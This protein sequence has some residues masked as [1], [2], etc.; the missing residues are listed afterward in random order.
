M[1]SAATLGDLL[2]SAA[3]TDGDAA[4]FRYGDERLSYAEWDAL[5]TRVAGGLAAAGVRRGDVVALLLPTTPLYMVCYLGAARLGAVTTGINV[6]YRR[7]EIGHILRRSGTTMLI[8]AE[9]WHDVDFRSIVG[10]LRAGVPELRAARWVPGDTLRASTRDALDA[11]GLVGPAPTHAPDADDPVAIVWTSGTTGVPKGAWYAHRNLLALAE[12]EARRHEGG[13]PRGERHLAS[14]LS[15]AHVGA[16]ARI[17][18]QLTSLGET[19]I[20]DTFEP[21]TVLAAIERER[22]VNLGAFPTQAIMLLDHPECARRDL[23]SLRAVLLG[24]AP[25]SPALIRRVQ[26]TFGVRVAV[27]YSSTEVG[28]ATGSLPDDPIEVLST[29]VGKPTPGVELRIV[30]EERREL[31]AGEIG[32]V[33]VRSPATMRGYWRDPD[34]TAAVLDADGWV[35]TG[36][37]GWLDGDGYLHLRG[38]QS[39]MFIRGGFNAYPAEIEDLLARHPKVARAAIVGLPDDVFG[40]VGWAF[41]VP[42]DVADPPTLAELRAYVGGELASFKRPDGLTLLEAL[43]LTPMFKVD[44]QVLATHASTTLR[45]PR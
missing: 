5:A 37:L 29:T 22:I 10:E 42:R 45:A 25:S 6:R 1:L 24:G 15:F 32:Q 9:T 14:G 19:I 3:Q 43:P 17:G 13:L 40:D 39:E 16:M 11:L 23:S 2:A 28:I 30:D 33:I 21:A 12:I 35:H 44:K 34:A 7:S 38:R 18:V 4:A 41:V 36:D 31:P 8:A 27:R 20:Y 26:E